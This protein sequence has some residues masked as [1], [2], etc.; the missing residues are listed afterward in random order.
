MQSSGSFSS[1]LT[2]IDTDKVA[3]QVTKILDGASGKNVHIKGLDLPA[4][5]IPNAKTIVATGV[6]LNV[7]QEG[8][9]VALATAM[10]E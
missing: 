3:E 5:Q 2:D 1:C 7:P 8:Q 6:A 10:Q 4:E 9:I